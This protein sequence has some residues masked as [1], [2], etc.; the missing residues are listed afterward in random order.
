VT[1]GAAAARQR[2]EVVYETTRDSIAVARCA[3]SIRHR[4]K[5][6]GSMHGL[7]SRLQM[8]QR[9]E[10]TWKH[11]E[12]TLVCCE[13]S[14][15]PVIQVS[16]SEQRHGCSCSKNSLCYTERLGATSAV[17]RQGNAFKTRYNLKEAHCS[18]LSRTH[19]SHRGPAALVVSKLQDLALGHPMRRAVHQSRRRP[20][21]PRDRGVS[22]EQV[23]AQQQ[24]G[25]ERQRHVLGVSSVVYKL[26]SSNDWTTSLRLQHCCP[27][28]AQLCQRGCLLSAPPC[29]TRTM[30]EVCAVC[31]W[32]M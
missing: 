28:R 15:H 20:G 2:A 26:S 24:P 21:A 7:R 13:T 30:W 27:C 14:Q 29:R 32:Q 11:A 9:F 5:T 8:N 3:R 10:R 18:L 4:V 12:C 31:A 19:A 17:Q 1:R 6:P 22:G 23:Q 25:K 16:M